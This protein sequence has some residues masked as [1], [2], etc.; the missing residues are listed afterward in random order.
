MTSQSQS[1]VPLGAKGRDGM[2]SKN[3]AWL[4]STTCLVA[5]LWT[6]GCGYGDP[7]QS[8]PDAWIEIRGR[9]VA[10]EIAD[11]PS[12]QAKGLGS[13]DALAWN[14]GMYFEYAEPAFYSFWMKDVRFSID[15]VWLR[16]GRIVDLDVRVPFQEG[17][18]GPTVRP[19]ELVDAVLEVPAG[20]A[21]AHRWQIGDRVLFERVRRE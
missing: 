12:E 9:R 4:I 2:P 17:S 5:L 18:N 19:A 20:Y 3:L 6:V 1:K 16:D 11:S 15:I 14:H 8:N 10:V 21:V 7:I 13:R